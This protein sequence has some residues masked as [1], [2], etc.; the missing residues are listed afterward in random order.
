MIERVPV[1]EGQPI[2]VPPDVAQAIR[3]R[4]VV[5]RSELQPRIDFL[6][7]SNEFPVIRNLI[8]SVQISSEL[9]LDITP[10][11]EPGTNWAAALLDLLVD[12]RAHFGGETD[13]AETSLRPTVP[14]AFGAMY[15]RQLRSALNREGPILLMRQQPAKLQRLAGRLDVSKWV[16][17]RIIEPH[18]FPQHVTLLTVDND[19][20][21]ALAWV[22]RYL[23]DRAMDPLLAGTL[24]RAAKDLRPGLSEHAFVDP[25]VAIKEIPTQWRGYE[26]AWATASAILR[27]VSLLHRGGGLD[28]LGVAVEPW[29]LLE[30]LLARS[31]RATAREARRRGWHIRATGHSKHRFLRRQPAPGTAGDV[32]LSRLHTDRSVEPDGCLWFGDQIVANFEAKYS[33]PTYQSSRQHIFQIMTT[34]AALQSPLAVL[35]YPEMSPPVTWKVQGFDGKPLIIAA[36]GLDMYTYRRGAGD[37]DR[38]I[39]LHNLLQSTTAPNVHV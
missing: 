2:N 27:R 12:E 15:L 13:N 7:G 32:S 18:L 8:G 30:R 6:A 23:A 31:L 1:V 16:T 35:V 4:L 38:G 25:S 22:A 3:R 21:S 29:P 14:D 10:K 17:Q 26:P 34:A 24:R 9:V 20:N 5:L 36:V 37:R 28:G 11:T 33:V 19:F 39:Q